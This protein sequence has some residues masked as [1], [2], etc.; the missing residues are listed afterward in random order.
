MVRSEDGLES[1]FSRLCCDVQPK[2]VTKATIPGER[3]RG[4]VRTRAQSLL[5]GLSTL[6]RLRQEESGGFRFKRWRALWCS[7]R[8]RARYWEENQKVRAA[9]DLTGRVN[10]Q[11]S[12]GRSEE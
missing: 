12:F 4:A 2:A 9:Q 10:A 11:S 6:S 7:L 1:T 8:R 3:D 5:A